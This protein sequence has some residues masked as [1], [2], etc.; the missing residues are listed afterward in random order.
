M[1]DVGEVRFFVSNPGARA[2]ASRTQPGI[3]APELDPGTRTADVGRRTPDLGSRTSD[4]GPR[5]SD[6]GP[7]RY[8]ALKSAMIAS[9]A[10]MTS[11][12]S[13]RDL[14]KRSCSLKAFVGAL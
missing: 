11:S 12:R 10:S 13:T 5:I 14:V 2:H 7:R 9:S 8:W 4:P 6:L 3:S 1:S